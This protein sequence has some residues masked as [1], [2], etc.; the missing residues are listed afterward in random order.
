MFKNY[1]LLALRNLRKQKGLSAINIF[2]LSI[3]LACFI[4]FLLYALNEFSFDRFNDNAKNIYRVYRW[5][6]AMAGDPA[7]GDVYMPMPLGPALKEEIP[8]VEDYV[9]FREGWGENFVKSE[10]K[11][12]RMSVSFADPQFFSVFTFPIVQGNHSNPLKEMNSLVLTE[13]TAKKLFGKDDPVGKVLEIKVEEDFQPFTITAVAKNPLPNSSIVFD[14]VGN[15]N[16]LKSTKSGARSVNNWNRSSY[17]T[18]LQLKNRADLA[19]L[20]PTLK[21]FRKKYYPNEES[22][23]RKAGYWKG[24]N[25]PVSY[26]LQPILSVHTDTKIQGGPV[27]QVDPKTLWLL[28]SIAAGVLLIACINF[29]TLAIGRSASRSKEVGIRK[30]IGGRK[31]EL[32]LQFLFEAFLLTILSTIIGLLLVNLLLPYFNDL[33]GKSLTFSF[34]LYPEMPWYLLAVMLIVSLLAGSYPALVLSRFNPVEALKSKIKVGGLNIFTRSLVT[35]QF[36]LSVGLIIATL[37][38]LQQLRYMRTKNPGFDKENIVIV[39]AEGTNS[40]RNFPLF[41]QS[42]ASSPSIIGIAGSELGLGEGTGWSRSGFDYKG[43]LKEVYE[44]YIDENYLTL[45]SLKLLAGRNFNSA[46]SSDTVTSVIVNEEMVKDFG[47]TVDNAVGQPLTG[48]GEKLT[49]VVIGVVKNFH[50]RPF[51]EEVKPQLFHRFSSYSPMKYFVK[52]RP[53]DPSGSLKTIGAAW[54]KVVPDFP[55]KYSFLDEDLDRF[56]KAEARW[57]SIVGWAGGLSI[58]LAC[59]GLLGLAALAV[60]NRTKEIGIR[61]VLGASVTGI[62][63]L[64]SKDFLWLILIAFV[65]ATPLSWY[66]MHRWLQDFAYRIDITIWVFLIAGIAAIGISLLTVGI[67]AF[68]AAVGNPVKSLRTE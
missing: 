58:F 46:I 38:I 16:F 27:E 32:I 61:K 31:K 47:W 3:G 63:S 24:K 48:Y 10:G 68:R 30:V 4:L 55:F 17:L 5:S 18:F 51:R 26:G 8:A 6:E 9:R 66:F 59:L 7:S 23:L 53:G 65:I 56:Y 36:V 45:L 22:E 35:M 50:F 42:L 39:D 57:S 11:I 15:F 2:G 60:L 12:S 33:A 49:P 67:Q 29:T 28:I 20:K 54:K 40:A 37:I 25:E 62:V 64:L 52:I 43:K 34:A 13:T 41:K 14:M 1:L 44:Y 19:S 21:T